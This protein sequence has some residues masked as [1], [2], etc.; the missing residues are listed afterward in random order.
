MPESNHHANQPGST[1][2]TAVDRHNARWGMVLFVIYVALYLGFMI[3]AA[4]DPE[5]MASPSIAG[6]NLAIVYG[7][8]LIVAALVLAF[9]YTLVSKSPKSPS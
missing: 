8:G 4:F 9:V 1:E 5:E 2:P 3:R 7:V 6:L